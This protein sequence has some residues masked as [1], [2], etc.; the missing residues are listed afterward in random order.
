MSRVAQDAIARFMD[1]GEFQRHTARVRR[2]FPPTPLAGLGR[3][4]GPPGVV[5]VPVAG[6]A[7]AVVEVPTRTPRWPGRV[8]SGACW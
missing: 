1:A 6:G 8:R 3:A 5:V 4:R 2:S 7:H